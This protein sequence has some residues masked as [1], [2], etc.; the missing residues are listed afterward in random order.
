VKAALFTFPSDRIQNA[1]FFTVK[2]GIQMLPCTIFFR[3]GVVVGQV[4]GFDGLGGVDDF[5]TSALEDRM[6]QAEVS[7]PLSELTR[8]EL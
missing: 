7:A 5:Q 8:R 6:H 2:L 1:P 4:L 3:R